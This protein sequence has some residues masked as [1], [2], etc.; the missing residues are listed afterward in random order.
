MNKQE[1]LTLW[2]QK[3]NTILKS[4]L[5][6]KNQLNVILTIEKSLKPALFVKDSDEL[7]YFKNVSVPHYLKLLK[8]EFTVEEIG[9]IFYSVKP[10]PDGK[11]IFFKDNDVKNKKKVLSRPNAPCNCNKNSMFSC[12]WLNSDSCET[13]RCDEDFSGCGFIWAYE[14]NGICNS[15]Y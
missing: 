3:L 14:C 15:F 11:L 2:K 1:K 6:T 10:L 9:S 5:L 13:S 8:E 4:K 12:R 7:E